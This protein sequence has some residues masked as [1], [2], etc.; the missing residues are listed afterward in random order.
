MAQKHLIISLIALFL[1]WLTCSSLSPG[2]PRLQHAGAANSACES[3]AVSAPQPANSQRLIEKI[4]A[5]QLYCVDDGKLSEQVYLPEDLAAGKNL[6]VDG[7]VFGVIILC[8]DDVAVR[9]DGKETSRIKKN[10]GGTLSVKHFGTLA[11][12]DT[13]LANL[14]RSLGEDDE[15]LPGGFSS[16]SLVTGDSLSPLDTFDI[17]FQSEQETWK[18]SIRHAG[19]RTFRSICTR[20]DEPSCDITFRYLGMR[21]EKLE[22][23]LPD[24]ETRL[25]A[26]AEGIDVV[27][28]SLGEDLVANVNIVDFENIRNAVACDDARDIW[29]Y[30]EALRNEPPRELR[31]MA[32]HEAL[33][34]YVE[35]YGIARDSDV[36]E[37]FA[38]LKGYDALSHERFM[39]VASGETPSERAAPHENPI[40]AFVNEQNFLEGA[41]GGHSQRSVDEFCVSLLHSL[42]FIDRLEENLNRPLKAQNPSSAGPP[43]TP[44]EK[45]SLLMDY[46]HGIELVIGAISDDA[47]TPFLSKKFLETSYH[48]AHRVGLKF[49]TSM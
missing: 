8:D 11:P 13:V 16:F 41:K 45:A 22:V 37:F 42:L 35:R 2:E 18:I 1:V 9:V 32:A 46:L 3:S 17:D 31:S 19:Y 12:D 47:N 44:A 25:L 23:E 27:E 38:D 43:P 6:E 40:F 10:R 21:L 24:L 26:I 14:R 5:I 36:R 48:K 30:I 7:H 4:K 29:F 49:R 34:I 33:H 28:S 15:F 20:P 39:V